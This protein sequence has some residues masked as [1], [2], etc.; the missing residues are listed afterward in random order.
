MGGWQVM[1]VTPGRSWRRR[2]LC[3][4]LILCIPLAFYAGGL[5][6]QGRS[7]PATGSLQSEQH[8]GALEELRQQLA[9]LQ[10]ADQLSQQANEKSRLT[11]KLLE[12]QIYQQQQDLA[13]Y[14][15]VV[16]PESRQNALNIKAFELLPTEMEGR[17]RYKVLLNRLGK[18]DK[19]LQGQL[20]ISVTGRQD[21]KTLRL[22]LAELVKGVPDA[23][24]APIAFVFK[25]FLAIPEAAQ[26]AELQL[27]PGFVAEKVMVRAEI[28]GQKDVVQ[29]F[30]LH[31]KE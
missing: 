22:P 3:G 10:S 27:P 18:G 13:F 25:H 21:G 23:Q 30:E 28:K 31:K 26:F 29:T 5:W 2:L 20:H 7:A 14:K 8:E 12:E 17:Y 15:G 19:P 16:A 6:Q 4:A 9:V 11:I 24:E 1:P